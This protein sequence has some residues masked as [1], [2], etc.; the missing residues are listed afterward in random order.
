MVEEPDQL[1]S[2]QGEHF[3][4]WS[5]KNAESEVDSVDSACREGSA[6]E[7]FENVLDMI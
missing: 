7:A 4:E 1:H 3:E 2:H 5:S 6:G